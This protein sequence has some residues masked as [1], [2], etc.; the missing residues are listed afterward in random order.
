MEKIKLLPLKEQEYMRRLFAGC[1][2]EI[3]NHMFVMEAEEGKNFIKAGDKCRNIFVIL[4][5]RA[6]GIDMQI[7]EKIYIFKEFGPGRILGE[8]E[9][10]SGIPEYSITIRA[11]TPCTF[12]V[13]PSAMYLRWMRRDGNAMFLRT[14]KLLYELTYQTRDDR[15][16]LL[17]NSYD[18]LILYFMERYEKT[19]EKERA[20]IAD[21]RDEIASAIGTCV[22][23][24]N[25][26]VRKLQE[27]GRLTL[28]GGRIFI[29][30]VQYH[31]MKAYTQEK[32]F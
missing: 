14:Q 17:L 27:Q 5:G 25:R 6:K 3:R 9:C 20:A 8:F 1:T 24:V 22:K 30:E 10:L 19:A 11:V 12:W 26:N 23:T 18:R 31:V 13:I 4:K 28:K 16:Y 15:K 29:S 21:S 32:L 2:E 7:Q